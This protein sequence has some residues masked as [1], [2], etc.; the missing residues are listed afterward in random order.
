VRH[1]T[2]ALVAF[3]VGPLLAAEARGQPTGRPPGVCFRGRPASVC[4]AFWVTEIGYYQRLA[5]S[6]VKG[7]LPPAPPTQPH[8]NS[9]VSWELGGMVNRGRARAVG[10]TVLVG[11]DDLGHRVG[12]KAR[13]RRW[14]GE[15]VRTL[16]LSAGVLRAYSTDSYPDLPAAA[17]GA[18]GDVSLGWG[19]WIA[20]TARADVLRGRTSRVVSAGYGGVRLGSYA[21][22]AATAAAVVA[23][24]IAFATTPMP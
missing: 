8:L 1:T 15:H 6:K 21:A 10:A 13:Y 7:V 23:A 16:D 9:H 11:F 18:T 20:V 5:A 12:V 17:Y 2:I 19:D 14:L 4:R 3:G 22:L 24:A